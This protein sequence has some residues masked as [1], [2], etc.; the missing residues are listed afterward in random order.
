L[1]NLV[2]GYIGTIKSIAYRDFKLSNL[3]KIFELTITESSQLLADVPEI[4]ASENINNSILGFPA[5]TDCRFLRN[6]ADREKCYRL[7]S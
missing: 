2:S 7:L 5:R 4:E 3:T 6:C 1:G